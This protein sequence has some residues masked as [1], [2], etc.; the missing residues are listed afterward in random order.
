[1]YNIFNTL[2]CKS[3]EYIKKVT[4]MLIRLVDWVKVQNFRE[5][6]IFK[7]AV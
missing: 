6:Q 4:K 1:M 2:Q 5:I 3:M 7:P